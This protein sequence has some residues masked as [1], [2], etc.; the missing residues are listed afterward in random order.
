MSPE[1]IYE[2]VKIVVTAILSIAAILFLQNCT[3]TMSISKYNNSSP[4]RIEQ[5]TR[6]DSASV[7]TNL[8]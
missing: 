7:I 3:A 5:S 6:V 1:K 2:I 8:K 4:Q